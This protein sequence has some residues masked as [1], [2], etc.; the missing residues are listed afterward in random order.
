MNSF[1]ACTDDHHFVRAT[2][3]QKID[4]QHAARA[5]IGDN[6]RSLSRQAIKRSLHPTKGEDHLLAATVS[7]K[8][9]APASS[10][11]W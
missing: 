10:V 1:I 8:L 5:T 7:M 2:L 9:P 3:T 11:C 6:F 4:K